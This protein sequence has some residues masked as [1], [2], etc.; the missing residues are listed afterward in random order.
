[1]SW[2]ETSVDRGALLPHGR[3]CIYSADRRMVAI[4]YSSQLHRVPKLGS[5][6]DISPWN[7]EGLK[8]KTTVLVGGVHCTSK[9]LLPAEI[10]SRFVLYLQF[11]TQNALVLI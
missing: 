7:L 4:T 11:W 2:G 8:V 5:R 3:R 10:N 6:S 9:L 1:M